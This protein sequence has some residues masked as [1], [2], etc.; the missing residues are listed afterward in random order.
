MPLFRSVYY[1]KAFKR[2]LMEKKN[3]HRRTWFPKRLKKGTRSKGAVRVSQ[4]PGRWAGG[5]SCA[6]SWKSR[7]KS[8]KM[9]GRLGRPEERTDRFMG[10]DELRS[11]ESDPV[12]IHLGKGVRAATDIGVQL[13]CFQ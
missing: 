12:T 10:V 4:Q 8:G 2:L 5:L 7:K 9:K 11:L 3:Q 1:E 6:V 13:S